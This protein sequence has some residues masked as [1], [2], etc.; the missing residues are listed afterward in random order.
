MDILRRG[1]QTLTGL[2]VW[3]A[4]GWIYPAHTSEKQPPENKRTSGRKD[5]VGVQVFGRRSLIQLHSPT[6]KSPDQRRVDFGYRQGMSVK[7]MVA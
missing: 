2:R 1:G 6:G 4:A 3:P 5:R 7:T